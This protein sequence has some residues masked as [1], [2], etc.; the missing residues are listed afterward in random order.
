MTST[1]WRARGALHRCAGLVLALA[2][3]FMLI[4]PQ[5]ALSAT[6]PK[7]VSVDVSGNMHVPTQTIMAVVQ[8][9]PG[10]PYNAQVVQGDLQ[11]IFALGYFSD[12]AAPLIRQR[13][14]GIAI[15]YRVIENPVITKIQ[16][17]G[18]SH[19]P[20]DTLLALMDTSVGQVLNMNTLRN[21]FLKINSY[22]D[23]IGYGGQ[24]PSH[25]KNLNIDSK[26]DA[27]TIDVQEGLVISGVEV[28]GDPL[29]PPNVIVPA[30]SA[31]PGQEFSEQMSSE[32]GQAVQKLYDKYN[33]LIGSFDEGLDPSTIDQKAGTAKVKVDVYIARVGL[34]QI[35]GNTKTKDQVIRRELGERPGMILTKSGVQ[36]DLERLNNTGFF[37]KVDVNPKPCPEEMTKKD[38]GCV[39]LQWIVTEQKTASASVGAGY[40]GGLTGQGLYGTIGYQDNNLHGTGNAVSLQLERGARSYVTQAQVSIPYVGNTPQSQ[41]WSL[42]GSIFG[43]GST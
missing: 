8:A 27:L 41:K 10:Q 19:V 16:F 37:S 2:S 30:L 1:L 34:V 9:R 7:I 14:G 15:T 6:A 42:G 13:P 23:R 22:Y 17:S 26:T 24:L 21:D 4:A 31:K 5:P 39:T 25:V 11:R 20:A 18:N 32:D 12:Q 29:L 40:S 43:N 28:G 38:P 35:T 3:I 36:R 33:L